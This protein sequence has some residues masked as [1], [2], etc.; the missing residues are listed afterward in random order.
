MYFPQKWPFIGRLDALL[1]KTLGS[2]VASAFSK[3]Y[4]ILEENQYYFLI[5][6]VFSFTKIVLKG[7]VMGDITIF[8]QHSLNL[9]FEHCVNKILNR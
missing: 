2:K 5:L 8:G 4:I 9:N 3:K 1:A 6:H 7:S